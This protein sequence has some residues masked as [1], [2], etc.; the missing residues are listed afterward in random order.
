MKKNGFTL[1]ELLAV[2]VI[3]AIIL[4][5][6]VPNVIS[7]LDKSKKDTYIADAK[8][9]LSLAEYEIGNKVSKPTSN[10]IVRINLACVDNEDLAKD[11]DGNPY[12]EDNSFVAVV[13]KNDTLVY[14]VHLMGVTNGG[15]SRGITLTQK[16]K[17]DDDDR[18]TYVDNDVT[19]L[20]DD[21]IKSITGVNGSIRVCSE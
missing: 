18:L 15:T 21:Q 16:E 2:I 5:I 4:T 17:L 20:S 12:D 8:K 6:A 7:S 3:L 19:S 11:P 9:F 14:Y 1:V 13:R 10:E